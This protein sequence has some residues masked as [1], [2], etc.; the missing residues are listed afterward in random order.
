MGEKNAPQLQGHPAVVDTPL[1]PLS[2]IN[3]PGI[4]RTG[5]IVFESLWILG[6]CPSEADR[7]LRWLTLSRIETESAAGLPLS[8][9]ARHQHTKS[10]GRQAPAP[11]VAP[12]YTV[13]ETT[14][15]SRLF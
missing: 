14:M 5:H 4:Q 9:T 6:V 12:G 15:Q 8:P 3:H 11:G 1:L 7:S 2:L 10:L 13:E